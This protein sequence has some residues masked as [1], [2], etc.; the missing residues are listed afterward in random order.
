MLLGGAGC[1]AKPSESSVAPAESVTT[2]SLEEIAELIDPGPQAPLSEELPPWMFEMLG[3]AQNPSETPADLRKASLAEQEAAEAFSPDDTEDLAATL[4]PMRAMGRAVVLAEQAVA[5]GPPDADTLAR[6]ERAYAAVDV[7]G[8]ASDQGLFSQLIGMFAIAAGADGD[9]M[10]ILG[11]KVRAAITRA[12][13]LHRRTVAQL[14]RE[15]PEHPAVGAALLRVAEARRGQDDARTVAIG[16]LALEKMGATARS[17]D[18]L[19]LAGVCM[20]ALDLECG[21]GAIAKAG[22]SV[23][24]STLED[25]RRDGQLARRIVERAKASELEPRLERAR[26]QLDLGRHDAALAEF[27]SLRSQFPRDARP[28]AGI[29]KHAIESRIDFVAANAIIEGAGPLEN[30]DVE[31]YEL[32][33]GT[34]AMAAIGNIVPLLVSNDPKQASN[35]VRNFLQRMKR[36]VDGF[37]E[38]GS[39]DARFLAFAVEVGEELLAQYESSAGTPSPLGI[40]DLTAR[41]VAL[42]KAIPQNPHAYRLLMSVSLFE[43]DAA[44]ARKAIQ[45]A[46]PT[47]AESGELAIRQVRALSDLAVSWRDPKLAGQATQRAQALT[48]DGSPQ[49]AVLLSDARFVG[50]S[51]GVETDWES[52]GSSYESL[53]EGSD[54]ALRA[55]ALNNVAMALY[56]IGGA[57]T[58]AKAWGLSSELAEDYGDVAKLNHIVAT[59]PEGSAEAAAQLRV[60]AAEGRVPDVRLAA[61]AWLLEWASGKADIEAA[62]SELEVA[63]KQEQDLSSRP[64]PPDPY[65]NVVLEGSLQLGLGYA[66]DDGLQIALDSYGAPWGMLTPERPK[67]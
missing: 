34:H 9:Q 43:N 60:L 53:L 65:A 48:S 46:P 55:R 37:A 18:W 38:L 35:A 5:S 44:V 58:A 50:V 3:L 30:R 54:D 49:A 47:G 16:K 15:A 7:P 57:E 36:N 61:R 66:V 29:A 10:Q 23:E 6:L 1:G 64:R 51:L 67:D 22:A 8:F 31:Y 41:V 25:V 14:L 21:D 17:E 59:T 62:T 11:Q 13:P 26:A 28:V 42:Q 52:V 24:A 2:L 33:I 32:A 19:T 56:Q 45:A 39:S 40:D 63:T 4:V 12:G 27:E 20:A